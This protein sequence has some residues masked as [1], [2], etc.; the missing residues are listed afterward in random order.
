MALTAPSLLRRS[1]RN[2]LYLTAISILIGVLS[3]VYIFRAHL[4]YV[5][6][7][8]G[9]GIAKDSH[10][11]EVLTQRA[12]KQWTDV[13]SKQNVTLA[14]A[15]KAY[16]QR[17]GRHPPPRFDEWFAF[18]RGKDALVVE[19]LFDRIHDD[20]SPFW[21]ILPHRIRGQASTF[22]HRISIRGG[23]VSLET[24]QELGSIG[25]WSDLIASVAE[26]LPDLDLAIN[27]GEESHVTVP[28]EQVNSHVKASERSK[29]IL[30]P[31]KVIRNFSGMTKGQTSDPNVTWERVDPWRDS[32]LPGCHPASPARKAVKKKSSSKLIPDQAW[33]RY[34]SNWT[35][36][37][38]PCTRP[39]LRKLHGTF[40]EPMS[41]VTT[42][43]LFPLFSSSKLSV[44]ND[45]LLPPTTY[46]TDDRIDP[47]VGE[48]GGSWESKFNQLVWRGAATGGRNREHTWPQF[49]RHRFV[50]IAN[51]TALDQALNSDDVHP[52]IHL[53][54]STT[55]DS[56][57]A[58]WLET[59][60]DAAFVHL[61]CFPDEGT[62]TCSYTD[63]FYSIAEFME[64]SEQSAS[65]Y[66][67]DL[68]GNSFGGR[69]R[70]LLLSTS[71][72][73]KATVYNEWHDARLIPW[74]HFVPMDNTF[75]DFYGIMEYFLGRAPGEGHDEVAQ[76]I[77]EEGKW[78][79]ERVLRKEDVQV[80]VYRLLLEYARICDEQRERLGFV[81]DL[82]TDQRTELL[83]VQWS[84]MIDG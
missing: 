25:P 24:D 44:N 4:S 79:A 82:L 75:G 65:K 37:K 14:E 71:L 30:S 49:H 31:P 35:E 70:S 38:D 69:F 48:I 63:K 40:I 59:F 13:W 10:P 62:P 20:L 46:W 76:K 5:S 7:S 58:S 55:K 66:L 47:G 74:A 32:F 45:I 42:Q 54:N 60:C 26:A 33:K 52:A 27:I 81:G 29:T 50:A 41:N 6:R 8:P 73:I 15:A 23:V 83:K 77:A 39:E 16:R 22:G 17:R 68:D 51:G 43:S 19:E 67:P 84:E 18:A 28:W 36:S 12:Q 72:P 9:D 34:V 64:M 56:G 80:Y 57:L 2:P 3:W 11:I 78:W 61:S 1:F 21:D 53:P